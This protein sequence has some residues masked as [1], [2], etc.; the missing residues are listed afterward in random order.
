M[1][2]LASS[3]ISGDGCTQPRCLYQPT[4]GESNQSCPG[5][6]VAGTFSISKS[7]IRFGTGGSKARMRARGD[8][9][10]RGHLWL[11]H[12]AQ[13][14]C[15]FRLQHC[16]LG[17]PRPV[18]LVDHWHPAHDRNPCVGG[19]I[20]RIARVRGTLSM[21]I[22]GLTKS[23]E[24]AEDEILHHLRGRVEISVSHRAPSGHAEPGS[25]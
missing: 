25:E 17:S 11:R 5:H 15:A 10:R 8:V 19:G 3:S 2:R 22:N 23:I 18:L 12:A 1:N 24:P 21:G 13:G 9:Y 20:E 16:I 14:G 4:K 6:V 7:D